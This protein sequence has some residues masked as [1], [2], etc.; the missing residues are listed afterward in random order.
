MSRVIQRF[1]IHDPTIKCHEGEAGSPEFFVDR[2]GR[3]TRA[4]YRIRRVTARTALTITT[5]VIRT[6]F[7]I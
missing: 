6:H 7:R 5:T 1:P 2:A 3:A 4:R